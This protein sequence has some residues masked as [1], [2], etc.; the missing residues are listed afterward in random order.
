VTEDWKYYFAKSKFKI[1]PSF[2]GE[3]K[4]LLLSQVSILH[5]LD[6]YNLNDFDIALIGVADAR[7][8]LHKGV[9]G[10]P[11]AVR[12]FL[13][14][15]RALSKSLK[16]LDLGNV[17]GKTIDDRY[18]VIED[19]I[20]EL[21]KKSVLPI[22]IGG[23]QDYTIPMAGAIKHIDHSFRLSVVDAKI[24]WVMPNKDFS[25]NGFLGLLYSDK[26]RRPYD[27]SVV[28]VQKYLFSQ[29]QEEQMKNA[30]FDFL[31]LGEIRQKGMI[32]AE[33]WLRD[34]DLI[35]C[36][37]TSL[38]QSDQPAHNFPMPNGLTGDEFCQLSWYA[39]LSDK[40]KAIG[41]FELDVEKDLNAQGVVLG[42]QAV[43]HVM[44]GFSLR[45]SDFPVKELD[46]YSQFIVHLDDYEFDIR[47]YNNPKNDRWWVEVPGEEHSEIVACSR[48]DFEDASKK[49]IPE[50]W[51][52]FVK[53]KAL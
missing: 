26:K 23:S 37:L 14:G 46:S 9:A 33:P 39:G 38:K 52:R 43:W 40:L 30:S 15:L 42:A 47:F 7:Y 53:K 22:V 4:D 45:Y 25:S 44:E 17:L 10:F 36:D 1:R 16:I 50:R 20:K 5:D 31:R 3:G 29:Y 35:S 19:V 51:F 13:Y 21:V 6:H 2:E 8:S 41:F 12:P 28:G 18:V 48:A 11:D 24:D 32:L 49:D 27:L 34:A